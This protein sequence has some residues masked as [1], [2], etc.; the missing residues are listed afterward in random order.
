VEESFGS[1][2]ARVR[3]SVLGVSLLTAAA[4]LLFL[5]AMRLTGHRVGLPLIVTAGAL[6][7][8]VGGN[9]AW[10]RR[11]RRQVEHEAGGSEVVA[12]AEMA[13]R[14]G[15]RPADPSLASAARVWLQRRAQQRRR[16][17]RWVMIACVAGVVA[18]LAVG[19]GAHRP[20][21]YGFAVLTGVLAVAQPLNERAFTR[22]FDRAD[23]VLAAG[24]DDR[25]A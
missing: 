12:A 6:G 5:G 23:A 24:H 8:L 1:V 17:S 4:Y 22:Y 3:S 19:F 21:G 20:L 11:R 18:G 2:V 14:L 10:E 13:C 25:P 16:N 9:T 7:V 15:E